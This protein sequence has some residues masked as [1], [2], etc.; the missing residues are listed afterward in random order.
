MRA[1][2]WLIS[3]VSIVIV[4][5]AL[6]AVALLAWPQARLASSGDALARVSLPG[7]AGRVTAVEVRTAAGAP[8]PVRLRGRKLWPLRRLA[9]GERLTVERDG[10]PPGLGG[11]ARRPHRSGAASRSRRPASIC[12]AAG[13]RC[14]PGAPVTVAFDAPVALVSLG[15]S[16]AHALAAPQAAVPLGVI[17]SGSAQRRRDRGR[18]R[19]PLLGAPAGAG[20]G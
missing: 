15:G 18:G 17:A 9:A 5:A 8:V 4:L 14:K 12:S 13:C 6:A 2:F 1:R 3:G 7:F 19:R 11:V 20:R 10:A 16:P